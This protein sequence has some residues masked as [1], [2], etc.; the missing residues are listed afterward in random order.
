ML[1]RRPSRALRQPLERRQAVG[2]ER[3][4]LTPPPPLL[5]GR[6]AV[7]RNSLGSTR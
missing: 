2:A 6:P 7:T 4:D 1:K 3:H 5:A